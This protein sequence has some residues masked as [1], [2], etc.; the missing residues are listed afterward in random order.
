MKLRIFLLIFSVFVGTSFSAFAQKDAKAKVLLDKSNDT[1][2]K[3]GDIYAA[4]TLNVKD[5]V[6]NVTES[7]DG[8]ISIKAEKFLIATPEYDIYFNGKTQWILQ[9][10]FDEVT[11]SEPSKDEIQ[12]LNPASLF[13]IYKK[14]CNYK[15]IGEKTDIKMRRVEEVELIPQDKK[16]DMKKIIVQINK[17][18]SMPVMF[19]IIY[20]NSIENLIYINKYQTKQTISDNSFS[21]D[22]KKYPGVEIIDL[23]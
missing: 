22:A 21:F 3:V 2:T 23:R 8:E 18:D 4:F 16:S 20:N 12:A 10:A 15:Y 6:N 14:G 13:G 5:M 9:K 7:F 1:F 11:V 19:H 17:A